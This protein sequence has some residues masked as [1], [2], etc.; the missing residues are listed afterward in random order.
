MK[1]ILAIT[2]FFALLLTSALAEPIK[3]GI[4]QFAEHPSLDNCRMGLIEG[5]KDNGYIENENIKIIYSNAQANSAL[6]NQLAED[7]ASKVDLAFSIATPA[8][9]ALYNY[10]MDKLPLVYTAVSDPLA[11]GLANEDGK[12]EHNITGTCDALPI[13]GQLRLIAEMLGENKKVG[14]LY[15]TSEVN[16]ISALKTYKSLAAKYNLEIVEEG[17]SALSDLPLAVSNLLPKV[18]CISNLTDN[19]VVSGLAL[20]IDSANQARKPVFGSE[21]EQVK[22]GCVAACGL[23]YIDLGKQTANMAV[24][25]L[26]GEKASA[27]PF[28]TIEKSTYYV[29]ADIAESLGLETPNFEEEV[30]V[31]GN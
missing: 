16:S 27:M 29:N 25:I 18:D 30:V 11:A 13:E 9:Q 24:R 1:K 2:L 21:I 5:L 12:N 3:I 22:R 15:T 6:L 26:K 19:T 7:M 14:I 28:E 10:S 17:I 20:L 23:E 8:A 4:L 31:I